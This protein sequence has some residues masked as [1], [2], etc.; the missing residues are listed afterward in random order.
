MGNLL[1]K[2][3]YSIDCVSQPENGQRHGDKEWGLAVGYEWRLT[4]SC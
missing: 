2:L 3:R 4:A 1:S